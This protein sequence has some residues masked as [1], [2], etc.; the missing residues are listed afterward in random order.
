[1]EKITIILADDHPVVRVGLRTLLAKEQDLVVIGESASGLQT[2]DMV[3]AL[4]PDVLVLDLM[5]ADMNGI[6]VMRLVEEDSPSTRVVILSMHSSEIYVLEA[7]KRG[8]SAYVLKDS[9]GSDLV[10]AI[11]EA[12]AGRRFLSPPL[13]EHSIE[14]YE[15]MTR[16]T[17]LDPY[18]ILTGREREILFMAAK[19][20]SNSEIAGKLSIST[21]TVEAHRLHLMRKLGLKK[22][23]ELVKFAIQKG[24]LPL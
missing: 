2:V 24:I 11:R 17:A 5:M 3:K 16:N 1:M 23:A 10:Q 12:V 7:F 15:S 20:F 18:D 22:Q 8:A 13:S 6:E 21:R 19:G 4:K 14:T 9:K